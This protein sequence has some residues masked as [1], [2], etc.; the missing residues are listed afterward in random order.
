MDIHALRLRPGDDLHDSLLAYTAEHA[1][2]AGFIVTCVGS[3]RRATLR[4]ADQDA[5]TVY[6]A[7]FEIVGL[8]GTLE[9]G[10]G[11]L[12][13]ALAA[14]DGHMIGGHLLS[15]CAVYTTAEIVIGSAP[16]L[17]FSREWDPAS[18]YPELTITERPE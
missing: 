2:Q 12:H 11:H 7:K 17:R 16:H 9:P 8:V 13:I 14:T 3:L 5:A 6:R 1:I 18:G 10:G 15:G 4:L